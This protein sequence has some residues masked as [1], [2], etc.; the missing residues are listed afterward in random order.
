[1]QLVNKNKNTS[2]TDVKCF[3]QTLLCVKALII[4]ICFSYFS[5]PFRAGANSGN[6]PSALQDSAGK[7]Y[8]KGNFEKAAQYY[9]GVISLGYESPEIYFNLGNAYYKLDKIGMSVLN[10]ER[11]KK[12]SPNDEEISFNLKLANQKTIDKIESD[13][14]LFLNDWWNNIKNLQSEKTWGIRSIICFCLFVFFLGVFIISNK[15]VTKQLGFWLGFIFFIF[16]II[17]FFITKS[18]YNDLMTKNSAVILS[19]SV[20]IKNAPSVTGKKLFIL[21]EGTKVSTTQVISTPEGEWVMV[22][23]SPEKAGWVKRPSLEFI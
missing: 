14:Q 15:L 11:A 13:T 18:K 22:E 19:S 23:V 8:S 2:I 17:S 3:S 6:T 5:S 21:H 9:E 10:Y 7:A 12:I 4:I 20:E 16:S 1:M